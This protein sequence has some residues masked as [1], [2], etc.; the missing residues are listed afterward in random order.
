MTTKLTAEELYKKVNLFAE[1]CGMVA[2]GSVKPKNKT[3][4]AV[5]RH[6]FGKGKEIDGD[7][8]N[9]QGNSDYFGFI[10]EHNE[11]SGKYEDL[12]L[13]F[14]PQSQGKGKEDELV[15]CI[16]ALGVG[17]LGLPNDLAIASLPGTRRLFNRLG[18]KQNNNIDPNKFFIKNDF[19]DIVTD[20]VSD[21]IKS[22]NDD[23]KTKVNYIA[24]KYKNYL[25][26]GYILTKDD[27]DNGKYDTIVK[28]WVAA[29]AK[30]RG[31]PNKDTLQDIDKKVLPPVNDQCLKILID[32][33][34]KTESVEQILYRDRFIVLQG[35]PGTGK[36]HTAL[37]IW[38]E[39]FKDGNRFFE[40]FHAETTYSDF[41]YGIRPKL[42]QDQIGYES[43]KGILLK[44]IEKAQEL[45]EGYK[46]SL[47]ENKENAVKENRVLLVIDEINRANL[48]NVLGPVFFLFEKNRKQSN[49]KIKFDKNIEFDHLPENLFV[50][51]TMNTA[52]RSLAVVDFA[53]RRRFTWLTLKP[54]KIDNKDLN[55][56]QVFME[57]DFNTF[58]EIFEKYA[59]DEELNLQPGQSYFIV[60][61]SNQ[62]A[63]MNCRLKYEL[64]P[65]IKEYLNEGYLSNAKNVFYN[66]FFN[67]IGELIYE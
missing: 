13:V 15:S 12:S 26:A 25:L 47:Q 44:A 16:V 10:R 11:P 59:N 36:T 6:A 30:F 54:H 37:K 66:Y 1:D 34:Q 64:M 52:D 58:C 67:R 39:C 19:T 42:Q 50:I 22:Y 65:L 55:N 3:F 62:L 2:V 21:V 33:K 46:N 20:A 18:G 38:E 40:Q 53:L 29:Y 28:M 49:V 32:P 63:E 5:T 31:W 43:H 23:S 17:T 61:K 35:A 51:A 4:N 7:K 8:N 27:F 48:S 60:N 57:D 24:D 14:F 41:V 56:N 9:G 45:E